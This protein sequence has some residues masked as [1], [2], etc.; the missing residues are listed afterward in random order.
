MPVY[1]LRCEGCGTVFENLVM[2]YEE[3]QAE[4]C[5]LCDA[6]MQ[7]KPGRFKFEVKNS[8]RT[9]QQILEKRFKK[10]AKRI[11]KEFT[12]EQKERLERFCDRYGCRKTY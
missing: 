12:P 3:M 10:R 8:R 9:R 6:V 5:P 7:V 1:D 11:E 2:T 4:I